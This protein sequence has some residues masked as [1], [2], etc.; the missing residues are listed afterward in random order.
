MT[1]A[2]KPIFQS[3]PVQLTLGLLIGGVFLY[4][5][6]RNVSWDTFTAELASIKPA[7][8]ILALTL[9]WV[10]LGARVIRW[11]VLLSHLQTPVSDRQIAIAFIAGCAANNILPAKLGEALRADLLGRLANVSR[12]AAFGSI[13]VERLFDMMAILGMTAWGIWFATTAHPDTLAEVKHGLTLIAAPVAALTV[14]VCFLATRQNNPINLRIKALTETAQNLVKGLNALRHPSSYVKLVISSGVIW[15]LNSITMWCIL[16][17]L[18]VQLNASQ[19]IL[20][21]GL[22]GIAAAIPAAPAGIGTLQYAFHLASVLFDFAPS[23][24]LVAATLVQLVLL[25]SA[26][27]VGALAYSF[28]VS[29]HLL[30]DKSAQQ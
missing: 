20:L 2:S 7:W 19:T 10:E 8:I 5:S 24:A 14:V 27:A 16:M 4:L 15:S 3:R 6:I 25:G 22:T 18:G 23:V 11:R 1:R 13:I 26:T 30:A 29:H 17:A 21:I 9:Y 28:A 12:V